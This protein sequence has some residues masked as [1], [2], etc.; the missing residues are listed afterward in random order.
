MEKDT[1]NPENI[2]SDNDPNSGGEARKST[3]S[4]K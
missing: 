3:G 4:Q 2:V 1:N